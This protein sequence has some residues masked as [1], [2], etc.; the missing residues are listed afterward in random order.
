MSISLDT[1]KKL[2]ELTIPELVKGESYT[3]TSEDSSWKA[4]AYGYQHRIYKISVAA[5]KM[6]SVFVKK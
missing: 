4:G 1:A 6:A 3:S 2:S 5:G